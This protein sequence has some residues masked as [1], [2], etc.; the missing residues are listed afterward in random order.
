MSTVEMDTH[1]LRSEH[2][3]D[4]AYVTDLGNGEFVVT[5]NHHDPE[6]A[7]DVVYLDARAVENLIRFVQN[8][9]G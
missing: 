3:G 1:L 2:L 4:G 6:R 7:T 9:E 8:R 5:A